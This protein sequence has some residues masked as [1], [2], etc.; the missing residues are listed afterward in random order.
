MQWDKLGAMLGVFALSLFA[1]TF[2]TLSKRLSFIK[3]PHVLFFIL[4]HF[5]TGVILSTA[6]VHLLQDAFSVLLGLPDTAP[7]KHWV[8]LIVLSALLAIFLVEYVSMAYVERLEEKSH[9]AHE[10]HRDRHVHHHH[11]HYTSDSEESDVTPKPNGVAVLLPLPE[12]PVNN[13]DTS[14]RKTQI[15]P[16]TERSSLLRSTSTPATRPNRT[17]RVMNQFEF[18][19]RKLHH[20]EEEPFTSNRRCE[21]STASGLWEE[22]ENGHAH[23]NEH[24][25]HYEHDDSSV[26]RKH[27]I[28]NTLVL[29]AG[30]MIHSLVIGLT[31]SIKSG[32]EFTSLVIAILFH[33]L[34]EGLS[35]GVRLATLGSTPARTNGTNSL[36]IPITLATIFALSVPM[37]CLIG[38]LAL[39]PSTGPHSPHSSL[40]LA[41]GITSA[42]SAG[43]LIY[44]S[45]VELLAGDFLHSSLRESSVWKQALAL[46]SLAFGVAGMAALAAFD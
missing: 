23:H 6:F 16:V 40:P 17:Q 13:K 10:E 21:S 15:E 35:L 1:S 37:G 2:P 29:Q 34:F 32:P 12:T 4:K 18:L 39:G 43:T 7:I 26:N 42:L 8:G 31:L 30:I 28:V 33:Q 14:P 20:H 25:H 36:S 5:G 19:R 3:V 41:Q 22:V 38:R 45:G 27:A 44:A 46:V 11:D 24:V 9:D